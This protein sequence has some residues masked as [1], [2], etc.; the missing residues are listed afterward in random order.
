MTSLKTTIRAMSVVRTI[1]S[2]RENSCD[3]RLQRDSRGLVWVAC[4]TA[5]AGIVNARIFDVVG[6]YVLLALALSS[7]ACLLPYFINT[8]ILH[9]GGFGMSGNSDK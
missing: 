4:T 5:T 6:E 3:R 8:S 7:W 9:S 2:E 1:K